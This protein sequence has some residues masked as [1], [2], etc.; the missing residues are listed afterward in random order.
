M[1]AGFRGGPGREDDVAAADVF[2]GVA[3]VGVDG[4][5]F[6]DAD[7]VFETLHA[8]RG[9]AGRLVSLF[10]GDDGVGALRYRGAGHD[11]DGL[12][13]PDL[14]FEDI[15]GSQLADDLQ[16]DGRRL[17]GAV[18]VRGPDGVAVHGGVG[19]MAVCRWVRSRPRQRTSWRASRI[20]FSSVASELGRSRG[21]ARVPPRR[22]L[23]LA[24]IELACTW[25]G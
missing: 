7:G 16:L 8:L 18:G 15:A 24:G 25:R 6:E 14:A 5:C 13:T 4:G 17:R 11:T 21:C 10:E 1:S 20:G 2:A 19:Q 3:E 23:S 9:F 12:A 22:Q